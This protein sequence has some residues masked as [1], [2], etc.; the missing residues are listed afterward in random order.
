MRQI[1]LISN[2]ENVWG[3]V[4]RICIL[5]LEW[6]GFNSILFLSWTGSPLAQISCEIPGAVLIHFGLDAMER[7]VDKLQINQLTTLFKCLSL[8]DSHK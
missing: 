1:L 8:L 7:Y 2:L 3:A 5:M 6:K 4:W